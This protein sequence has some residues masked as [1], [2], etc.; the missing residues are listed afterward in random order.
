MSIFNCCCK[1]FTL[2]ILSILCLS[3]S[4][5]V[6]QSGDA[7]QPGEFLRYGVGARALGMGHAFTG[8]A[9]DASTIYWNP[10]GLGHMTNNEFQGMYQPWVA[11]INTS[12]IGFGYVDPTLGTFAFGLIYVGYGE[13]N[14]CNGFRL[15]P[16]QNMSHPEYGMKMRVPSLLT[17]E[18]LYLLRFYPGPVTRL[19]V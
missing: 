4:L 3:H 15:V 9:D 8:L 14:L 12:Y 19:T 17:W 18:H 1:Y 16:L 13:E 10:A 5:A 7:G 11:D 6:A 2:A